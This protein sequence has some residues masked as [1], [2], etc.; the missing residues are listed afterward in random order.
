MRSDEGWPDGNVDGSRDTDGKDV[1]G[2]IVGTRV[3]TSEGIRDGS[4]VGTMEKEGIS[5]A[6]GVGWADWVGTEEG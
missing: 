2:V 4:V 5:E 6:S 1:V 3:G